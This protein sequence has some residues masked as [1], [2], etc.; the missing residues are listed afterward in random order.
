MEGLKLKNNVGEKLEIHE[1]WG[2]QRI[3]IFDGSYLSYNLNKDQAKQIVE[4]LTKVF[5]L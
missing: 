1:E 4:H 5:E 3:E 2:S